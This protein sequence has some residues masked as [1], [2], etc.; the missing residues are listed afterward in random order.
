MSAPV[1]MGGSGFSTR[2]SRRLVD[3]TM[4]AVPV[5]IVAF[6]ILRS[7]HLIADLPVWAIVVLLVGAYV[8]SA[9]ATA[10][11]P[12]GATDWRVGL[13]MATELV[14]IGCV[15][16]AIGWG[17]TLV[18]GL[19]FG[20]AD[21]MRTNGSKVEWPALVSGVV[22]I[23]LGQLAI[24]LKWAPSLIGAPLVHAVAVLSTIGFVVTTKMLASVFRSREQAQAHVAA[25]E[26][27]FRA[28]VQDA[29][30]A[31]VV[32]HDG[33]VTYASPA[34]A[35]LLGHDPFALAASSG[36]ELVHPDDID[37]L[38]SALQGSEGRPGTAEARVRSADGMWRWLEVRL[39]DRR[40]D[41]DVGGLVANVRDITDRKRSEA[42]LLEAEARFRT[43]FDE[44]P[45]G[46][47]LMGTD[48]RLLRVN[49]ALADLLGR[50]SEELVG[51][52]VIDLTHPDDRASTEVQNRDLFSGAVE[53]VRM[54]KRFLRRD[55]D[56]VWTSIRAACVND[57]EGR[58]LYAIKQ[59]EDITARRR[60]ELEVRDSEASFRLLFS[61]N[62]QPMWVYDS[63]TLRFM[64]VNQAAIEH[65]GYSRED[66][67]ARTIVDIRPEED[68]P[69]LLAEVF[70]PRPALDQSGSWRHLCNDGRIID[71]EISSHR[72]TFSGREA[73]LVASQDVTE[74]NAMERRLRHQAEHDDLTGLANR[75]LLGKEI[76][77]A[78]GASAA[79]GGTL[80]L[81][82]VDVD[83]FGEIND[84]FGLEAGDRV[85]QQVASILNDLARPADTVA[86]TGSD[87]FAVLLGG[88]DE[89][90][91][92]AGNVAARLVERLAHPLVLGGVT[93]SIE[94]T[95]GATV[96]RIGADDVTG[97]IQRAE[98]A[99]VRAKRSLLRYEID[100]HPLD[101][102]SGQRVAVVAELRQAIDHRRLIL[103][104]QPKAELASGRIVGVEALV[105]WQHAE[106]GLVA[107]D[108]FV[109]L[110]E[111]TGLIRPLTS[112]VL[113]ESIRQLAAW[114]RI[115]LAIGLSVNLGAANLS[116]SNLPVELAQLLTR[117]GVAA[118]AVTLEITE[119]AAMADETRT[120]AVVAALSELGVELS[121]DDFGTGYSSLSKLRSLPLTEI[122][123]DKSFVRH[124][125]D[126]DSEATIIRSSIELAHH[127]G[128]RVVGEGI[129]SEEVAGELRRLGCEV[130][131]G[132]WLSRPKPSAEMTQ[133]LRDHRADLDLPA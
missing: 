84:V 118:H 87:E 72:L 38:V 1:L 79:Q 82:V 2:L 61:A 90:A 34:F 92:T 28:L 73:V 16:Y 46:M 97:L 103:H 115:G 91:F 50:R 44:A 14:V 133:W 78:L 62:P 35:E 33:R 110:A 57:A 67:L 108:D 81:L 89:P 65:Y 47:S 96:G 43:A 11:W 53:S 4:V 74:R 127:L 99:L 130:G 8:L 83:N 36:R 117:H 132:Y 95:V 94:A 25:R 30:D 41:P 37:G 7:H 45:I 126:L 69:R 12:P 114:H 128:L 105:R 101:Q 113:E 68:A 3:P 49:R 116:D 10:L 77:S 88:L 106:R 121:V 55:G 20:V 109:P 123:L 76:E 26:R 71:V 23:G 15:I 119:G 120:R 98:G 21:G 107:P 9:T 75:A 122:K 70:T 18:V 93:I 59:V 54:E 52:D 86:R 124:A 129:E 32:V 22:V 63:H 39:A 104:Y 40:N 66:F 6:V 85:L 64:E 100:D 125:L 58:P 13:S 5:V 56:V 131:Q 17:P 48:G 80:A 27:R 112:Y 102:P 60:I 42:A 31:I 111:R 19:V 51:V 29:P 24:A